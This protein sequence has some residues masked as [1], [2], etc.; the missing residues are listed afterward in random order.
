MTLFAYLIIVWTAL[1]ESREESIA[2]CYRRRKRRAA[3]MREV[4]RDGP[5]RSGVNPGADEHN[6]A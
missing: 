1:R 6:A 2:D 4:T 5:S 3:V